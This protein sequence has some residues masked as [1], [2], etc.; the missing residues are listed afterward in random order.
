MTL[1]SLAR[2]FPRNLLTNRSSATRALEPN[3]SH[4]LV[5]RSCRR[6]VTGFLLPS[7]HRRR[8]SGHS[9]CPGLSLCS[10]ELPP[11]ETSKPSVGVC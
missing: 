7:I 11:P 4:K 3:N 8:E 10:F 5:T 6:I 1:A 2:F 9:N